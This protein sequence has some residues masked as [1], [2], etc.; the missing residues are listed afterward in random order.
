MAAGCLVGWLNSCLV[1]WLA[2]YS[3]TST[4]STVTT[5]FSSS[6][7]KRWLSLT[8]CGF[9]LSFTSAIFFHIFWLDFLCHDL[10]CFVSREFVTSRHM[11]WRNMGRGRVLKKGSAIK[12]LF[13]LLFPSYFRHN[14]LMN[15]RLK[16]KVYAIKIEF[17][18]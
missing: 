9:T 6:W 18:L 2:F 7:N 3:S 14:I 15:A 1:G 13:L 17:I 5:T 4:S 16:T 12:R 10:T 8:D 11:P